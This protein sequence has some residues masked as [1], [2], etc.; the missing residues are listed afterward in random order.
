M[1]P[2]QAQQQMLSDLEV[3][4]M[5]DLY[6]RY[7]G[8]RESIIILSNF[9]AIYNYYKELYIII[10]I[11]YIHIILTSKLFLCSLL[12]SGYQAPVIRSVYLQSI[13]KG[14]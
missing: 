1:N 8:E 4:M 13:T 11:M 7:G 6:N 5:T 14:I 2:P 10:I 9:V 3:D 12:F